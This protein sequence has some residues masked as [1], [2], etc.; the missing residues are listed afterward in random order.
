[1]GSWF[2]PD[3][4]TER[5]SNTSPYRLHLQCEQCAQSNRRCDKILPCAACSLS[6]VPC[7]PQQSEFIRKAADAQD[8]LFSRLFEHVDIA[9]YTLYVHGRRNHCKAL[10]K[11]PEINDITSRVEILYPRVPEEEI[12]L[13]EV[14]HLPMSLR[15]LVSAHQGHYRVEWFYKGV[16]TC[17]MSSGFQ[18]RYTTKLCGIKR[19]Y[20]KLV[21]TLN[22]SECASSL[23]MWL[24]SMYRP[25]TVIKYEGL[26]YHQA[27]EKVV[28]Q[29][30]RMMSVIYDFEHIITVTNAN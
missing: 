23:K 25:N 4:E 5:A 11:R 22:F 18:S 20:P 13:M 26:A 2:V 8:Q 28:H 1:M 21:Q 7:K 3:V 9:M 19:V 17:K 16:Y 15:E 27:S 30:V 24:E 14:Q 10:F 6:K 29:T 12:P